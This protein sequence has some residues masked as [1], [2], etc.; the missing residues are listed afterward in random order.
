[1]ASN[2]EITETSE[3]VVGAGVII[4]WVLTTAALIKFIFFM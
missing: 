4:T 3:A 2:K 1:M